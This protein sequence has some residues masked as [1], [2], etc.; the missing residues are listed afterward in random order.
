MR[1][2]FLRAIP[3]LLA[4]AAGA[5]AQ[6]QFTADNQ[7]IRPKDYREWVYLTSGLGM[8]Y[9]PATANQMSDASPV[10]DNVFVN[11]SSY[12]AFL[13]TGKWPD[14][15]IFLL[16][17]RSSA[18]HGSIN[19][20]GHFQTDVVAM[21]AAVK[22]EAHIPDKW[23]Y[24]GFTER[25]GAVSASAKIF[26]KSAGCFA[27][28]TTNGAVDNTFVQFY[29]AL[30]EVA[31]AKGTLNASYH[32]VPT[33]TKL[34]RIISDQGWDKGHAVLEEVKA[35]DPEA[36]IFKES[37]LNLMGYRLLGAGKKTEAVAVLKLAT[38]NYPASCNAQDSLAEIYEANG[39]KDL[40]IASSEKAIELAGSD[41]KVGADRKQRVI[42]GAKKRI[43]RLRGQ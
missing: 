8:S 13:A 17:I 40:A 41:T 28:H 27:C 14:K 2:N 33:P 18:S 22:D 3:V 12:K 16:E 38:E 9:G 36:D 7:L 1:H 31:E 23:G 20:N 39:Q 6:P 25:A 24:F 29:P 34:V 15:T 11:P 32:P 26:P 43:E 19:K 37:A 4:L 5:N 35:R 30:L 42:D 21:E 10:F